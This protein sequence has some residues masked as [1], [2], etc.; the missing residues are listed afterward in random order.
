VS[1]NALSFYVIPEEIVRVAQAA[2]PKGNRTLRVRDAIGSLFSRVYFLRLFSNEGRL[3]QDPARL[4]L[5]TIL[6]FAERLSD[7]QAAMWR[8]MA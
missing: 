5:I 4:A 1:L 3:A 7:Q 6:Q 2:F 8:A